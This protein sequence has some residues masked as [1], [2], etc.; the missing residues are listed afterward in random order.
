MPSIDVELFIPKGEKSFHRRIA[1]RP[2]N[3]S[4]YVSEPLY[5]SYLKA[6]DELE[7]LHKQIMERAIEQG[8]YFIKDKE[9]YE[10][11]YKMD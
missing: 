3:N 10:R 9:I 4:F 6:R 7:R 1:S 11:S 5:K 2:R 8:A